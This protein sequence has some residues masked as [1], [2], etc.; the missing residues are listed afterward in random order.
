VNK[1]RIIIFLGI[2]LLLLGGAAGTVLYYYLL[3]PAIALPPQSGESTATATPTGASMLGQGCGV[4][5]NSD[6]TYSFSWLHVSADGQ[7]VD[8][9]NC[10]VPLVGFNMG[11]LF[12]KDA[13]GKTTLSKIQWYKQ[14][15][16]MNV[17]RVNFNSRWW[18]DDVYVPSAGMH[19]RAWLQKYISWQK[20]VGNYV[21]L[22]KG[23]HF[24]EPPCDGSDL[25]LCPNQ[26]QGIRDYKANP[27]AETAREL[28]DYIGY[29]IP[30]LSDLAKLYANDPAILYDVWNEPTIKNLP[31]FYQDMNTL[32]N[33]VRRQNPA[34]L[35]IVYQRGY[36]EIVSGTYP[37]YTQP[38]LVID[39]HIYPDFNGTSPATGQS[40]HSPGKPGWT[41]QN[42][43]L[44]TLVQFA[45]NHGHAFIINEWGG[46]YDVPTYHRLI[47]SYAKAQGIGLVYFEAGN[48]LT[49]RNAKALA[50][51][52]NGKLVQQ[53]YA[54]ILQV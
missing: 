31:A 27:N 41:P 50:I 33:T 1:W 51:N 4:K 54:D 15:F 29:D 21:M 18:D 30:A 38:N 48:V 43:S 35:I 42:S 8:E 9:K 10:R 22:D 25:K 28:E 12:I 26:D 7:V 36:R 47:T 46:C 14:T 24:A 39:A 20:Q 23:P 13:G 45:H 11:G 2:V 16:P 34:S 49:D 40:C 53:A 3:E 44:D 37:D 19:Y 52:D 32:I 17:A 6:G 5:Q